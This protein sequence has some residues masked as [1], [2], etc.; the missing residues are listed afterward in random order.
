MTPDNTTFPRVRL[1][2]GVLL[3]IGVIVAGIIGMTASTWIKMIQLPSAQSVSGTQATPAITTLKVQRSAP[4]A[5]LQMTIVNA[6]Y[7]LYFADDTIRSGQALV[8][9]NMHITNS[10]TGQINVL[11]Y[12][13]ARLLIPGQAPVPPTN[14]HLS[15]GP[16]PGTSENGW[17]DFSVSSTIHLNTL[18]LQL[19]STSLN[20]WLVKIPFTGNFASTRYADHTSTQTMLFHY[21]YYGH[22]LNYHLTSVDTRFAYQGNQTK[23]GQQF[24]VLNFSVD[25]PERVDISPG[26]GFDYVRL[27]LNG[28]DRPPIDNS[29]PY[30]FK[31]NAT[32]VGGH[33]VFVAPAGLK[34]LTIG[35][36]AQNGSGEQDFSVNV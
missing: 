36:L 32:N 5:G 7:A 24:Y 19:G 16:H 9:L 14:V 18:T 12:D 4:Y 23:V 34:T 30:T 8:R 26:F 10:T 33:A 28:S 21:S 17:L 11:Y 29:L 3:L 1:W 27:V 20:E 15:V 25:N 35:F 13:S 31:A 22:T 6:Q 2:F